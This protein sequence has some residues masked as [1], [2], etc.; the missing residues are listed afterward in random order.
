M[1][2]NSQGASVV[3]RDASGPPALRKP[4]GRMCDVPERRYNHPSVF[5]NYAFKVHM[6]G[7][8]MV[9]ES[10]GYIST[11]NVDCGTGSLVFSKKSW[12]GGNWD[13]N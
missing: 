7:S 9:S 11:G 10:H 4:S 12:T 1:N 6:G 2:E 8:D 5:A 3:P 13:Q